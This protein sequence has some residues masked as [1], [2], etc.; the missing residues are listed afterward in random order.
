LIE[1]VYSP[2]SAEKKQY[3]TDKDATDKYKDKR[4]VS[5]TKILIKRWKREWWHGKQ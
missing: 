2:R 5:N 1:H 4:N 3:K